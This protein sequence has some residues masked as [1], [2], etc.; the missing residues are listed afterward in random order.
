M[1][2]ATQSAPIVT[3][4]T[5]SGPIEITPPAN[6]CATVLLREVGRDTVRE[7][8]YYAWWLVVGRAGALALTQ[9]YTFDGADTLRFDVPHDT[10]LSTDYLQQYLTAFWDSDPT[11]PPDTPIIKG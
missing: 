6:C 7:E 9:T 3:R 8:R 10:L 4:F 2:T 5:A 1:A 11:L